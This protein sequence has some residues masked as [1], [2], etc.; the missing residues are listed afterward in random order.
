MT[1][2][3][4][5]VVSQPPAG[6][7]SAASET[8]PGWT[9]LAA[10][11]DRWRALGRTATFWWRD[12]DAVDATPALDRLLSIA[13]AVGAPL[14]LAVIPAA[15]TPGLAARLA[16]ARDVTILQHGWSHDNRAPDGAKKAEL[17]DDRPVAEVLADL[18]RGR[19]RLGAL[20]GREG[21]FEPT[22]LV[23]PW[24]RIGPAVAAALADRDVAVS[25]Y[26]GRPAGARRRLDTHVD[27]IAWKAPRGG[28][29]RGFLGEAAALRLAIDHLAARRLGTADRD[30]ATGLLTHHRVHDAATWAFAARFA[31]VIADHSAAAWLSAAAALATGE[32]TG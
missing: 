24:N 10:E 13:E 9:D 32:G 8:A 2:H 6:D 25:R 30:E 7:P 11:L 14:A 26:G 12:D 20:F 15:A 18:E 29:T 31:A 4:S 22:L 1:V 5:A 28:D 23:P 16:R 27:P 17:G 3:G 19:T 21:R